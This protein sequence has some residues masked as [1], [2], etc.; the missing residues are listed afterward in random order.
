MWVP[1]EDKDPI[2]LH[3]PTRKSISLFGAASAETGELVTMMTNIFNAETFLNFLKKV[4]KTRKKGKTILMILDN[5][6]YHHAI[7]IQPWLRQ[8]KNKIKLMFLPPY[9]PNLNNVER[10][11]K[12]TRRTCTHNKYF[13]NLEDLAITVKKQMK[14]W[15]KP[16]ETIYKL[17]CII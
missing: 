9:S 12:V 1:P 10:V 2:L 5:A 6:R 11:W 16:N 14:K 3:A 4:V 15:G 17:C 8:N 7:M 13:A